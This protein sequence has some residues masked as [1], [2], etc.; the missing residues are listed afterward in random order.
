MRA[1]RIGYSAFAVGFAGLG[2]LSLLSGDF[3]LN[4]QPVPAWVP[5]RTALAYA[6][7]VMLFAGGIGMLLRRTAKAALLVLNVNLLIWLL[8]L[9]LPRVFP[10][11]THVG[12]WLRVS[13]APMF[14][15]GAWILFP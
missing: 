11:P 3:A 1:M 4:W 12:L 15:T 2:L 6:S 8:L 9:R 5:G 14:V 13:E 7:G 10:K